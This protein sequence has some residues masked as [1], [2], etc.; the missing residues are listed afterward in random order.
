MLCNIRLWVGV[1]RVDKFECEIG[2]FEL[3]VI[4]YYNFYNKVGVRVSGWG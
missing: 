4:G 1:E 2:K 3:L